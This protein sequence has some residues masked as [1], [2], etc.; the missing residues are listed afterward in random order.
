MAVSTRATY[1]KWR[2]SAQPA[3]YDNDWI[4]TISRHDGE[5]VRAFVRFDVGAPALEVAAKLRQLANCVENGM[6]RNGD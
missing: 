3:D 4:I 5:P 1:G 6:S 2:V